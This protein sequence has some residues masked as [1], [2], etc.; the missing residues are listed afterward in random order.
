MP[1]TFACNMC[2][3]TIEPQIDG[4]RLDKHEARSIARKRGWSFA[5]GT[6]ETKCPKHRN[7]LQS[8]DKTQ[9]PVVW[10]RLS[11]SFLERRA[12]IDAE[13][14]RI[15]AEREAR[16]AAEK[17]AVFAQGRRQ[18]PEHLERAIGGRYRQVIGIRNNVSKV[19]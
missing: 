5:K 1:H 6:G 15:R 2:D 18:L 14:A 19:A 10:G 16:E 11:A 7:R 4:L 3:A 9:A 8:F 12:E 17:E 13:Y